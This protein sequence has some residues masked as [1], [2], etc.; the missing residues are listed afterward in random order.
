[1]EH[2]TATGNHHL[3]IMVLGCL[4]P[5]AALGAILLLKIPVPQGLSWGLILL[6][7]LSHVLMLALGGHRHGGATVTPIA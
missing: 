5:L 2:Q 1:M 6:C 4:I 7:P 3:W